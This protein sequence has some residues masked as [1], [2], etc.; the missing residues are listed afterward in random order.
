MPLNSDVPPVSPHGTILLVDDDSDVRS[1]ART[2]LVHE[3]YR[4]FTSGDAERATHVFRSAS[5][6]DLLI[7]D[8]YLPERSGMELAMDLKA[9]RQ[10]LPILMISGGFLDPALRDQLQDQGWR[11]LAKPFSLPELLA[12][13]HLILDAFMVAKADSVAS[14]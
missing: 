13:V 3:G 7:V 2:F 4:V 5:E 6:I 12:T 11:F 8:L 1:L 9:L 10:D 14:R